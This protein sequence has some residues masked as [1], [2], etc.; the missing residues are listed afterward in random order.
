MGVNNNATVLDIVVQAD[1]RIVIGGN[2]STYNNVA[3]NALAR[4]NPNGTLD[5]SFDPGT[6]PATSSGGSG[7][8]LALALQPDGK[9][10]TAGVFDKFQNVNHSNIARV[11]G[12]LSA[13][14]GVSDFADKIILLPIVNDSVFEGNEKLNL[15]IV[16]L[17]VG[18]AT[19]VEAELTIID[20]DVAPTPAKAL[21]IATR[22]RVET[23]NNVMIA[24]FIL[25]GNA[26]KNVVLRGRG[27]V[28]ANFGITD[29]LADPVLDLRGPG[30]SI[31]QN[32]DWKDTQ[33][34]QIEGTPFE[35]TDDREAVIVASLAP[36]AY[37]AILTGNNN[38][39]GVG[40]VEVFDNA[41]ASDSQLANI[42]TRGLV[43][44]S[45]GVM[46]G[47]FILGGSTSNSRIAIRGIG[48]SLAQFGLSN[49][50]A[51]PTLEL[52]DGNGALL[53]SNDDW[54]S[55]STS[56]GQLSA[57]GLALSD[58]KESGIFTS[59]PAGQFTAI[60]AGKNGGTGIGLIEIYNLQ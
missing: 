33:R 50:L 36:D 39:T 41:S 28:L 3:R 60:L 4:L 31:L 17:T 57:N 54:E 30:G 10:I 52:H 11:Q 16:P 35:P 26:S 47:G 15:R 21:N 9:I 55:D 24:G 20:N 34:A 32:N 7:Q 22:L 5:P 42:S 48:P 49:V 58:P 8:V 1:G 53:L 23:G 46:I 51:D 13:F 2:F 27:P 37:T 45:N 44:G 59:L 43:Q 40:L 19:P 29:F 18:T 56:A 6:G 12:D 38:T 14:W 25:T